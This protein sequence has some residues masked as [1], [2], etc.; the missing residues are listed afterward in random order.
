MQHNANKL[1]IMRGS[2]QYV[3]PRHYNVQEIGLGKALAGLGW[4]VTVYS[5]GPKEEVIPVQEGLVWHELPRIGGRLTGWP[6][7]G[8]GSLLR[9]G[10]DVI[11]CQDLSNLGIV[12][13]HYAAKR[14]RV[15]LVLSLGEYESNRRLKTW[16]TQGNAA[17]IR[18]QV[19]G[20]LCKTKAAMRYAGELRL[21]PAHYA[22]VGIDP[23]AYDATIQEETRERISAIRAAQAEG[24]TVLMHIGR[25]DK[26]DNLSFLLDV[27]QRVNARVK[28]VLAGEPK[29][30]V[31]ALP[32]Y[33]Q[34][35]DRVWLLGRVPNSQIGHLLQASDAYMT[36]SSYEPFGMAAAESIYH[37]CPVLGYAAGGIAEIV[38]HDE[39]GW[40]LEERDAE[41]WARQL[42]EFIERGQLRAWR[43]GCFGQGRSLLW[44][45]RAKAYHYVYEALLAQQ[46]AAAGRGVSR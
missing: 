1:A 5:S 38:R 29:A 19:Q 10:A 8:Y 6:H 40:L 32:S 20:V 33:G 42:D 16:L 21:Q 45:E 9:E 12:S 26:E 3:N 23:D 44:A 30:F 28:L 11:Q 36:C 15:P 31:E 18:S 46:R 27:M 34:V 22:P 24:Y 4:R 25:M 2:S 41:A 7:R 17:L 35:R 13:A 14:S 37:G 43:D 39:S